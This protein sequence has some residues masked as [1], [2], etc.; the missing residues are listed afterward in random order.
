MRQRNRA[1]DEGVTSRFGTIFRPNP[2]ADAYLPGSSTIY[3]Q[4]WMGQSLWRPSALWAAIAGLIAGGLFR[5]LDTI[6]WQELALLCLLVDMLWGAIWRLSGGREQLLPLRSQPGSVQARLPY[7]Q[8]D[9]PAAQ[10]TRWNTTDV[11]PWLLRVGLPTVVV[12]LL[13]AATMGKMAMLLTGLLV[14]ITAA[15]WAMRRNF[16]QP[17]AFWQAL[18]TISLPWL[19]AIWR[20]GITPQD[21]LWSVH[22]TLLALWTIHHWAEGRAICFENDWLGIVLF[23]VADAGLLFLMAAQQLPLWVAILALLMLPTWYAIIRR[24]PSHRNAFW[25]WLTLLL[26][27]VAISQV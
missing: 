2:R 8:P 23:A 16:N 27:A 12:A 1:T 21:G 14:L 26:S 20:H 15:G 10:L 19:L 3:G 13:V 6:H 18:A 4:F 25:W 17:P 9:S 24:Q 7:L 22:L 5:Q 11:W